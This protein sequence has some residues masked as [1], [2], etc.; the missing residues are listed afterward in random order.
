MYNRLFSKKHIHVQT[1]IYTL[2]LFNTF[3]ISNAHANQTEYKIEHPSWSDTI[4]ST[5]S[6]F[7]RSNGDCGF[8]EQ[9]T[10]DKI[11]IKWEKYPLETFSYDKINKVWTS[12]NFIPN[13]EEQYEELVYSFEEPFILVN[14]YGKTPTAAIIKFPTKTDSQI[15]IRIKGRNQD[16]DII[17]ETS[18]YKTEHEIEILGLYP[19]YNNKVIIQAKSKTGKIKTK[20]ITIQTVIPKLTEQWF[21]LVKKDKDFHY[22]ATYSGVVYDENGNVRYLFMPKDE[23]FI[24]FYKNF[25][26]SEQKNGI[27]KYTL[28]G[29]EIK[30]YAYPDNFYGYM[31]G[32]NFKENG[33][34]LV[35]G[36]YEG[37]KA[38][39]DCELQETH[40]DFVL[41]LD[42]NTGEALNT[43]DLAEMLNPDRSLIVK[44]TTKEH[45]KIDWAHTNGIDYD[46]KN[47]AIIVSG[48][49]FGIVKISEKT[50]KPIWWMTPH[51]KTEKSGRNGDKG[52]ISHLL[53]TAIDKKNTPYPLDVQK[54]IKKAND[55]KWPLKTHSIKYLGKGKYSIFDNSGKMW[56]KTL[57][58]TKNSVA[59]VYEINDKEKTV[60]QL[61]LKELPEYS[62][63][64]SSTIFSSKFQ[65]FFITLSGVFTENADFLHNTFIYRTDLKGNILYKGVLHNDNKEKWAFLIYPYEFYKYNNWPTPEE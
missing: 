39:I 26:Y 55:F 62:E 52:D 48:R 42:A 14:P 4:I 64:G 3:Y 30:Q 24:Y 9:L 15:L 46:A 33:N 22:Y 10:P 6:S 19:G 41:E 43:Y 5:N 58:T 2:L 56:D 49:H 31:H 38:I 25:V 47:K 45:G 53:L 13:I 54:G 57:Y 34:I 12:D 44:S 27:K 20:N 32:I 1:I 51:Q 59:S 18:D 37:S 8:I 35:F 7:C 11:L 16:P 23:E 50:K 61:F 17:Y 60:K 65:Q 36:T 29:K 63:V 40:R 21:P 28:L